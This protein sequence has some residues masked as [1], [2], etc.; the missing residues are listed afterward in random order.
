MSLRGTGLYRQNRPGKRPARQEK[1][2]EPRHEQAF[3]W[4]IWF[5]GECRPGGWVVD[6]PGQV[7]SVKP[8]PLHLHPKSLGWAFPQAVGSSSCDLFFFFFF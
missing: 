1:Q 5:S 2:L 3:A 8:L 7:G 4:H 6:V